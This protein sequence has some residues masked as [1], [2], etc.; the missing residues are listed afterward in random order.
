MVISVE[1][2]RIAYMALPKAACTTVK[3]ALARID[4]DVRL[5]SPDQY[6]HKLWHQIYPTS[7]FHHRKWEPYE[8]YWTFC[9]VR[10]PV[11]RLMSCFTDIVA[12][13]QL[14]HTSQKLR[15]PSVDLPIDPDPDFF[16][17]NLDRY[18]EKASVVKHHS[19]PARAFLGRKMDR[20]KTVYRTEN[21]GQLAL[22]LNELT[23]REIV[24]NKEN[25]SSFKLTLD[26]LKPETIDAIRP[27]LNEEYELFQDYFSNPI[28][29]TKR[30]K[31]AKK[32][33]KA[34]HAG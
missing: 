16:F 29:K 19:L 18:S 26:D 6:S 20:Y 17:Q 15:R 30:P 2:Y 10:D 23:G 5:P 9:V 13:R 24:L 21:L 7:R 28:A 14:L 34:M 3:A 31:R 4:L 12:T 27:R 1:H 8:D 25:S 33:K 22:D 11:K 32:T